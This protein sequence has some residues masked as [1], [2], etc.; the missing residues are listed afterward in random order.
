MEIADVQKFVTKT[1]AV[2]VVAK[3]HDGSPR[4]TLVTPGV[5]AAGRVII[6]SRSTTDKVKKLRAIGECRCSS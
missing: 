5:D 6:P 2:Q 4:I 1:T 3:K